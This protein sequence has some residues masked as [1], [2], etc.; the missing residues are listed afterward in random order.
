MKLTR[1]SLKKKE[2]A[3][4][5]LLSLI[6]IVFLLWLFSLFQSIQNFKKEKILPYPTV[7]FE[8]KITEALENKKIKAEIIEVKP[9]MIILNLKENIEVVLGKDKD[10]GDQIESLQLILNEDKINK[11]KIKKIDLR[12]KNPVITYYD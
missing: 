11:E 8:E 7:N 6:I 4:K 1:L 12:F 3:Q 2:R 5:I 10:I 9:D